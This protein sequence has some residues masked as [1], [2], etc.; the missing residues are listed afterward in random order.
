MQFL[1]ADAYQYL[2]MMTGMGIPMPSGTQDME[3]YAE[4]MHTQKEYATQAG[5][6][7]LTATNFYLVLAFPQGDFADKIDMHP[8]LPMM[9]PTSGTTPPI[10]GVFSDEKSATVAMDKDTERVHMLYKLK[11]RGHAGIRDFLEFMATH[12]MMD[13]LSGR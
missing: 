7:G 2:H 5:S 10:L 8:T 6:A 3:E 13:T 4:W 9:V 11:L 12:D 1:P